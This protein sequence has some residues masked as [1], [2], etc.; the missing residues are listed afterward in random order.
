M[1]YCCTLGGLKILY[2]LT[3]LVLRNLT[4]T[5][6]WH[7]PPPFTF[8]RLLDPTHP[9]FTPSHTR[10]THWA[11]FNPPSTPT[12]TSSPTRLAPC[13]PSHPSVGPAV[14]AERPSFLPSF[15]L[16]LSY[17]LLLFVQSLKG[18]RQE[19]QQL[20]QRTF[21]IRTHQGLLPEYNVDSSLNSVLHI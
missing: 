9:L 7:S 19:E 16:L 4:R 14:R 21:W 18:D 3:L 11:I 6:W 5:C 1:C 2:Y 10:A 13:G 12:L 8:T 15:S 20:A 17:G